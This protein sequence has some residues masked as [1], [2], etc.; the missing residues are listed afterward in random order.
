LDARIV[1]EQAKRILAERESITPT[2][3]FKKDAP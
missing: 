1:I 2:E 3:A